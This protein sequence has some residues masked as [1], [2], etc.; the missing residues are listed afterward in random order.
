VPLLLPLPL[1]QRLE[2]AAVL[3]SWCS[4]GMKVVQA[5]LVVQ[6]R[7][8]QSV[9]DV[10][11]PKEEASTCQSVRRRGTEDRGDRCGS[12]GQSHFDVYFHAKPGGD[13]AQ[14]VTA[15]QPLLHLSERCGMSP[16][17]AHAFPPA[18]YQ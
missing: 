9:S 17:G 11:S 4:A 16:A 6:D 18:I 2:S 12:C 13:L 7:G 15:R 3:A 1:L 5:R 10:G 14:I 8:E